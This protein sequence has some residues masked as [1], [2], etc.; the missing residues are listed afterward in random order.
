MHNEA[1]SWGL[2]GG[3]KEYLQTIQNLTHDRMPVDS[4]YCPICH[5]LAVV[6]RG[7][8]DPSHK[9]KGVRGELRSL[10]F[11][12]P[13]ARTQL[14]N[15]SQYNCSTHLPPFGQNSD[16]NYGTSQIRHLAW[17]VNLGGRKWYKSKCRPHIPIRFLCTL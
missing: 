16:L 13:E 2:V 3:R 10:E 9:G 1:R 15:I 7:F 5:R 4:K 11:R 8:E 17:E 6:W 14:P 12:Q